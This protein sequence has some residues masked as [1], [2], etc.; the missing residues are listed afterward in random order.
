MTRIDMTEERSDIFET[1]QEKTERSSW[2]I[3]PGNGNGRNAD[4]DGT[5]E[6][7]KGEQGSCGEDLKRATREANGKPWKKESNERNKITQ[8]R[9]NN[10]PVL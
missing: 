6:K 2:G 1:E 10:Q 5:G 7:E 9:K 4:P 3:V 8:E